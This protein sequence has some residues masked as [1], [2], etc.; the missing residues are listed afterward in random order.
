LTPEL[1][2][3]VATVRTAFASV[4]ALVDGTTRVQIERYKTTGE[5]RAFSK[6]RE[7]FGEAHG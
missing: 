1:D 4:V 5:F 2:V 6:V 3:F 7:F